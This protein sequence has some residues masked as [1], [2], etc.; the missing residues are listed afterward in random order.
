MIASVPVGDGPRY[1]AVT[2]DG[3]KAYVT[4]QWSNNT[5]V[6]NLDTMQI[7]T[8]LNVGADR[9]AVAITPDGKKAYITLP[10][11]GQDFRFDNK[12]AVIDTEKDI[13]LHEIVIQNDI[14]P[15]TIAMDPD[16]KRAYV[17]DGNAAGSNPSEVHVIDTV[18]DVYLDPLFFAGQPMSFHRQLT[19][20]QTVKPF[21]WS[22]KAFRTISAIRN[23]SLL[24]Q[25]IT[26]SSIHWT[27]RHAV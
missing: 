23:C 7:I 26:S 25:Q 3:K 24:I 27:S 5:S 19:L 4:N 1:I 6:I 13:L 9:S 20:L 12:V 21:L 14:E 2:P 18:K 16:G 11:S 8:T 17:P 10:G 15:L 22:A